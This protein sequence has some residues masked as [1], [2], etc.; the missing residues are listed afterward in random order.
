[1]IEAGQLIAQR[2]GLRMRRILASSTLALSLLLVSSSL[3]PGSELILEAQHAL[4]S[5]GYD[6]GAVDGISGPKMQAAVRDFQKKTDLQVDGLLDPQTLAALGVT[7][8]GAEREFDTAGTNVKRAYSSG[9][10][11]IGEGGKTLC[12]NVRHG[13]MLGGA[14]EFGKSVGRGMASISKGTEYATSN[15]IKGVKDVMTGNQ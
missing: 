3:A 15:A 7:N 14:K 1:M 10:K 11:Q 9:G 6:P 5:K 4:K 2:E 12:S 13:E 8:A